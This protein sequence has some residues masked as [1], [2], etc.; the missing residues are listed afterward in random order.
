MNLRQFFFHYFIPFESLK[1]AQPRP[2]RNRAIRTGADLEGRGKKAS[3]EAKARGDSQ[4]DKQ[5][6]PSK[7]PTRLDLQLRLKPNFQVY[8]RRWFLLA[9]GLFLSAW[10]ASFI[11]TSLAVLAGA[12]G[13][14]LLGLRRL[15][16]DQEQD[17]H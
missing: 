16:P 3:L 13:L 1:V 15:I 10:A 4:D 9:G 11:L 14:V 5:Q 6:L 7:T 17:Q 2:P 8:V 12:A